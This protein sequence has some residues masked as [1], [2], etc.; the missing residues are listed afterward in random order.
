MAEIEA[1]LVPSSGT[2]YGP[3]ISRA[4]A[5]L[6]SIP[7]VPLGP[8]SGALPSSS[9]GSSSS[10][11]SSPPF[12][13]SKDA[14]LHPPTTSGNPG[15]TMD[16]IMKKLESFVSTLGSPQESNMLSRLLSDLFNSLTDTL[17]PSPD[18]LNLL[19]SYSSTRNW[20]Q[21]PIRS[22][23][24]HPQTSKLAL[25][26]HDDSIHIHCLSLIVAPVLK[27]KS[28]RSITS[29]A[30]R[31]YSSSELA[32]GTESGVLIWT[33][34]PSSVV[35]RPSGSCLT[36]LNTYSSGKK[37]PISALEYDPS[38][39]FLVACSLLVKDIIVW[40]TWKEEYV[41]I[42]RFS[43]SGHQLAAWSP[44]GR[45]LLTGSSS[46]T[47]RLWD[48]CHLWSDE[49]WNVSQGHVNAAVWSPCGRYLLFST[50]EGSQIY[51]I[52]F[53]GSS[54]GEEACPSSAAVPIL[55]LCFDEEGFKGRVLS[56]K[57]D[58]CGERLAVS[59]HNSELIAL[60]CS[61][62]KPV[63]NLSL[64]GLIR[65]ENEESSPVAMD[66]HHRLKDSDPTIL[67]IGWSDGTIQHF[68]MIYTSTLSEGGNLS[69]DLT[70]HQFKPELFSSPI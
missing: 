14:F 62:G 47:I 49:V 46:N 18:P 1:R 19:S 4:L 63:L 22:L 60:F 12:T 20:P 15:G 58:A 24:W 50:S 29:L 26:L 55:D 70:S 8:N 59:F 37:I 3:A 6:P 23:R 31:P 56:M 16:C 39:Q 67:T 66:F 27:H 68:P 17:S 40:N 65:G 41:A 33:L 52:T 44:S 57:W 11:K 45:Y 35:A 10:S 42:R 51:C 54:F 30:W 43:S 36:S 64:I 38:G 25:A 21:A 53:S 9:A 28:Q 32:V 2:S 7:P 5:H 13:S 61:S 48:T 34:D 69:L